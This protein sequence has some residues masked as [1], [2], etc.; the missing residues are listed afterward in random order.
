MNNYYTEIES[1]TGIS[2]SELTWLNQA[3]C[4]V[5]VA[6]TERKKN[7]VLHRTMMWIARLTSV[8]TLVIS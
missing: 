6:L 8:K 5:M 1:H 7:S 4:A 3:Y 2:L